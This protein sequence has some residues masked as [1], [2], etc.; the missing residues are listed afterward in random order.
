MSVAPAPT[1][2]ETTTET[3]APVDNRN[4]VRRFFFPLRNQKGYLENDTNQRYRSTW[5]SP[6]HRQK[7]S[8]SAN[9]N[10]VKK[11]TTTPNSNRSFG[12]ASTAGS[13]ADG[14][15]S[16][17]E[18]RD[19]IRFVNKFW[20]TFDDLVILS[21]FTQLGILFR[22]AFSTWF[23]FIDSVF[24]NDTALFTTLP[25]NC[26]SCFVLG[27]LCSGDTLMEVIV[28][29]FTPTR[30]QQEIQQGL[31]DRREYTRGSPDEDA[32][33]ADIE[34]DEDG[35]M[36]IGTSIDVDGGN[37]NSKYAIT[38]RNLDGI[39][40]QASP[41]GLFRR[42]DN[43]RQR[44]SMNYGCDD[45]DYHPR[46][47]RN[48]RSKRQKAK[49]AIESASKLSNELRD[50]QI[51]ALERRIRMSKCLVLFP[52][53][54]E[55][56]DVMEHYFNTG[57]RKERCYDD[58]GD[59]CDNDDGSV[60]IT[61]RRKAGPLHSSYPEREDD[62]GANTTSSPTT[63]SVEQSENLTNGQ[64]T[65][66]RQRPDL[67][68]TVPN[69]CDEKENALSDGET[70]SNTAISGD[71]TGTDDSMNAKVD[72]IITD[73]AETV[74]ENISR[75]QRV[76]LMD[77]WD[78][79]T[80]PSAM[81]DD[82]LLGMRAGF[83][84]A[85][86]SFSSWNSAMVNLLWKGQYDT[87]MMGYILGLQL[88][89]VAYRFGQHTALYIF[90]WRI[91]QQSRRAERRGYGLRISQND[92][93]D[94]ALDCEDDECS[95]GSSKKKDEKEIPS[96][97]A[98]VTAIFVIAIVA[99]VTSLFFYKVS[100]YQQL[101]FSL[102]FSPLGV[103]ARWRLMKWNEWRP[104][105]PLGTFTCNILACA[106]GGSLGS[107]LAGN[108]GPEERV[109]MV[110]VI[111][112]FGGTLSSVGAFIEEILA[113]VDPI[114]FRFDGVTY[115]ITS[116]VAAIG[117]VFI[118]STTADWA[119]QVGWNSIS[120]SEG[121]NATSSIIADLLFNATDNV[122]YAAADSTLAGNISFAHNHTER[123]FF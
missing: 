14:A 11:T 6:S 114:L 37:G 57:Y 88:P 49:M 68:I 75:F 43:R 51:L 107:L 91:R 7:Q 101:A 82:L 18:T 9:A 42:K 99:Q 104:T 119:D 120:T 87:A 25:L 66:S 22:L 105:F 19:D 103:I 102:L 54:Q 111:S 10:D 74:N 5:S 115:A 76:N 70:S 63:K 92:D 1:T 71:T 44:V 78:A 80:S 33:D 64:D 61:S 56:V 4:L 100:S 85:L 39:I 94:L 65:S 86:S 53:E 72:Q 108:P 23:T 45:N 117:V 62:N 98:F 60:S 95:T 110:G 118:F 27:L 59:D 32:D 106:L 21:I 20:T 84:G 50:V 26:F 113:G 67:T 8:N 55:D 29:R 16:P 46:K 31:I 38:K 122:T 112:G 24:S 17:R 47:N 28:T 93:T 123:I 35:A 2:I 83:C 12:S 13:F 69:A 90:M 36:C 96:V 15:Q 121:L 40:R 116:I 79:G 77:G 109:V 3:T 81:A 73:V 89:I 41:A 48:K 58:E 97:R 34:T 30:T 52:A